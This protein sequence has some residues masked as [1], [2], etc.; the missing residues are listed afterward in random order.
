MNISLSD[1]VWLYRMYEAARLL[2]ETDLP[3]S[4]VAESCGISRRATFFSKFKPQ[5]LEIRFI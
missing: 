1:A 5:L 3:L 4:D 2:I